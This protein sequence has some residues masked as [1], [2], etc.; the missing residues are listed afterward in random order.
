MGCANSYL[1]LLIQF[2]AIY[3]VN[4]DTSVCPIAFE[5]YPIGASSCVNN[6]IYVT[7][8]PGCQTDIT[9]RASI[10][11]FPS[12][13]QILVDSLPTGASLILQGLEPESQ[14]FSSDD[15]SDY[16]VGYNATFQWVPQLVHAGSNIEPI[17]L[18]LFCFHYRL[19]LL[20][21][22]KIYRCR[23]Q[24]AVPISGPQRLLNG[25]QLLRHGPKVPLLC[26][27][28]GLSIQSRRTVRPALVPDLVLQPAAALPRHP[29]CRPAPHPR[30]LVPRAERRHLELH[31]GP[32][33]RL[34]LPPPDPQP[35]LHPLYVA[36][37]IRGQ[38]GPLRPHRLT[39]RHHVHHAGNL[40]RRPPRRPRHQLVARSRSACACPAR[41]RPAPPRNGCALCAATA[42]S[43]WPARS[44]AGA[45]Y[46]H[47][48]NGRA[49]TAEPS[50]S[51][52]AGRSTARPR[53]ASPA[54]ASFLA[55]QCQCRR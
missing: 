1:S 4:G 37:C 48:G 9:V 10:Y 44:T 55:L 53:P 24:M 49:V 45:G 31:L 51:R 38:R 33:R 12:L 35:R 54:A 20:N 14:Q 42:G 16:V 5:T 50:G 28:A 3:N 25:L 2:L 7:S 27:R 34:C 29:P 39:Q 11:P 8:A 13:Q 17:F 6:P 21:A 18:V 47:G 26:R 19:L 15:L 36:R 30:Q 52:P 43:R 23:P 46:S 32:L 40:R 41:P 22:H